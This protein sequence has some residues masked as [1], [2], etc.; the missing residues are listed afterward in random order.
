MKD[1]P[2]RMQ[3]GDDQIAEINGNA[4]AANNSALQNLANEETVALQLPPAPLAMPRVVRA[5]RHRD[6]RLFWAGNFLSN[7]GTWMQNVAQDWLVLQ[8]S[9]QMI[10]RHPLVPER[11]QQN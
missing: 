8:L 7:V 11:P 3:S 6:F 4:T 9:D 5:L 2:S 1:M 10:E